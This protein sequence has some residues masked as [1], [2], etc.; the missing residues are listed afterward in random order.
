MNAL[1]P[2]TTPSNVNDVNDTLQEE[3]LKDQSA[4]G[5]NASFSLPPAKKNKVVPLSLAKIKDF[6]EKE[7]ADSKSSHDEMIINKQP[8]DLENE[9]LEMDELD[10]WI[11]PE[12]P[13]VNN[14]ILSTHQNLIDFQPQINSERITSVFTNNNSSIN[15]LPK[16]D[17]QEDD[18]AYIDKS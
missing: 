10:Q 9:K 4:F 17:L 18:E 12:T 15:E 5:S 13:D 3:E 6:G 16:T 2:T 11:A 1:R 8:R 7:E 14:L